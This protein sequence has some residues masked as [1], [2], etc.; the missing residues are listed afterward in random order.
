M[1]DAISAYKLIYGILK[2][3]K[4]FVVFL[5]YKKYKLCCHL[6]TV[7]PRFYVPRLYELSILRTLCTDD[8]VINNSI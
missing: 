7:E 1:N 8:D 3:I 4:G 5:I 2:N 6:V